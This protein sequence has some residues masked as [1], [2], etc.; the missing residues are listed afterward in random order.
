MADEYVQLDPDV[1]EWNRST[2]ADGNWM[3]ANTIVPIKQ[4]LKRLENSAIDLQS[5][6]NQLSQAISAMHASYPVEPDKF[7]RGVH[8]IDGV[9]SAE[10]GEINVATQ[11]DIANIFVEPAS[12]TEP[13][14]P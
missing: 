4:N 9:V 6:A 13:E 12:A 11:Q 14:E 2:V 7:I 3:N 1:K 5:I 8:Q 10:Y